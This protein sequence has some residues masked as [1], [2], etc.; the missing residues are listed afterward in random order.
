MPAVKFV[1]FKEPFTKKSRKMVGNWKTAGT[2]VSPK[3]AIF[4]VISNAKATC[5]L[6]VP[7]TRTHSLLFYF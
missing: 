4:V 5:I 3:Q 6:K 7:F 2:S 1:I